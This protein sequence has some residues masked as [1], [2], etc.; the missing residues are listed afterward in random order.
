MEGDWMDNSVVKSMYCSSRGP[1]F[2]SQHPYQAAH[3][4]PQGNQT[5]LASVGLCTY[6]HT[7]RHTYT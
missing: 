4:Q 1:E 6:P 7:N 3:H 2:E 5:P